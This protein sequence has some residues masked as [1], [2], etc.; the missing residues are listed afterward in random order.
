MQLEKINPWMGYLKYVFIGII[1]LFIMMHL[2]IYP[3]LVTF[4]MNVR[5]IYKNAFIFTMVK[6]LPNI[7]ITLLC[8]GLVFAS[9]FINMA[10]GIILFPFISVSFIGFIINYYVYPI[11]KQYMM[12]DD[13]EKEELEPVMSDTVK[14]E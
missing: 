7:L 6:L 14:K 11:L 12:R 4:K 1:F 10:V 9:F 3:M 13:E 8:M 2:Y 5:Q